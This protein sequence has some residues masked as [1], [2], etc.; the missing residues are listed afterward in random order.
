M[1]LQHGMLL[2]R[3]ISCG[4]DVIG[5]QSLCHMGELSG[6][7]TFLCNLLVIRLYSYDDI[8]SPSQEFP[9][10]LFLPLTHSTVDMRSVDMRR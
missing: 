8:E 3:S 9:C 10:P 6:F 1:N 4:C 7:F 2:V 5:N